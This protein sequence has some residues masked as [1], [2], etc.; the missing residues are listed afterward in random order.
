VTEESGRF[1][2]LELAE[3]IP[4]LPFKLLKGTTRRENFLLTVEDSDEETKFIEE[5]M[6]ES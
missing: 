4:K 2:S 6:K 1:S 3:I 5:E